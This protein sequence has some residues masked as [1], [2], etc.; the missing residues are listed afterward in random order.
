[1]KDRDHSN[2]DPNHWSAWSLDAT[3]TTVG[4][5]AA[6]DAS[7]HVLSIQ[8]KDNVGLISTLRVHLTVVQSS[9]AHDLLIVDDTRLT[10]DRLSADGTLQPRLVDGRRRPS[11]TRSST[12]AED[13]RGRDI[14]RER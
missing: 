10:P 3:S 9:F 2:A 12:R 7:E 8:A 13:S 1:M 6:G 11:W 5:F 14:R 4:P